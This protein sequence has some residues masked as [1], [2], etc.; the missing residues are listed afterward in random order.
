MEANPAISGP[1]WHVDEVEAAGLLRLAALSE[2]TVQTYR[3]LWQNF[4]AWCRER[5]IEPLP[6]PPIRVADYLQE[7]SQRDALSTVRTRLQAIGHEH[8][9]AGH[10]NPVPHPHVK[11]ALI[12]IE[13]RLGSLQGQ[14]RGLVAS[15]MPKLRAVAKNR[16]LKTSLALVYVMRDA[17]LRRSE[18]TALSWGDIE[19]QENGSGRLLVRRS[20]TDQRGFGR[21]AYLSCVSMS[22]LA[23]IKPSGAIDTDLV[24]G[25]SDRTVARRIRE[26]CARAGCGS[27]Y[28]GHSCKVGM[29]QDLVAAGYDAADIA[30]AAG[31]AKTD[32]VL[33]YSRNQ[34][35]ARGAVAKFHGEGA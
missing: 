11:I 35:A 26:I 2:R 27:G 21:V 24:F 5:G 30:L 28:S 14:A 19:T 32:M 4:A 1:E 8:V 15:D 34:R 20:K 10:P 16:R 31:W 22:A 17:L 9:T 23:E 33:R 13:K 7:R 12:E 29:T 6:C 25:F 18:A 3:G